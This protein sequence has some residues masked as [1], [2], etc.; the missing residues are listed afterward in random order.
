MGVQLIRLQVSLTFPFYHRGMR[1]TD[2]L[3]AILM[4]S[5]VTLVLGSLPLLP[6]GEA[7]VLVR[8][9]PGQPVA[10][11]RTAAAAGAVLVSEP[12]PG[13]AVLHGDAARIRTVSGLVV[14]WKGAPACLQR[15]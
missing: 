10:A 3:P 6:V 4:T 5:V 14:T 11:L 7:T 1:P 12:A 9:P 13:F 8:V 15:P 2:F